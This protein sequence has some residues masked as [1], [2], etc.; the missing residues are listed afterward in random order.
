[1]RGKVSSSTGN[2][3]FPRLP[4]FWRSFSPFTHLPTAAWSGLSSFWSFVQW[5]FGGVISAFAIAA[6]ALLIVL[7][8]EKQ[9]RATG[10]TLL[11]VPWASLGMGLLTFVAVL[12]VS[13]ILAITLCLSPLAVLLLLALCLA[14]LLGWAVA[15]LLVG[16]RILQALRVR[17]FSPL[18]AVGIG[19][20]LLTLLS[21]L[22]CIGWLVG[23]LVGAAGLGAVVLTRAGT[24]PYPRPPLPP[25]L[26]DMPAPLCPPA[27]PAGDVSEALDAAPPALTPPEA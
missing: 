4:S 1:V 19:A 3:S 5:V 9:V 10:T 7:L 12:A 20:V 25:A 22:P 6:L 11:A 14:L 15:G 27:A 8:F 23:V 16:E 26:L 18:L 2:V 24:L 17:D 21:R 13:V